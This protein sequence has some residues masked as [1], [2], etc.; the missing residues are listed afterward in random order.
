MLCG[1][2]KWHLSLGKVTKS[3]RNT[4]TVRNRQTGIQILSTK[5]FLS[6]SLRTHKG[7]ENPRHF[8]VLVEVQFT[9]SND[10]ISS[11]KWSACPTLL[12]VERVLAALPRWTA[13]VMDCEGKK[14]P[15]HCL[16]SRRRRRTNRKLDKNLKPAVA[17]NSFMNT[18]AIPPR[19][20][21]TTTSM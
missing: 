7:N 16:Q 12:L 1:A 17:T 5:S 20:S 8:L 15:S 9:N 19:N 14:R 18:H 11:K 13:Q 3:S 10:C 4:G 6:K 21:T 2:S